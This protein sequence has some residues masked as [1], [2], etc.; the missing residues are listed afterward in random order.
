MDF[1]YGNPIRQFW[2][3]NQQSHMIRTCNIRLEV[4][5]ECDNLWAIRYLVSHALPSLV[6]R[7]TLLDDHFLRILVPVWSSDRLR[8][9]FGYIHS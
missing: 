6:K 9:R 8:R 7:D 4:T 1:T 5:R 3:A 2:G